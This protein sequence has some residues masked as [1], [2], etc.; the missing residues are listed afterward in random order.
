MMKTECQDTNTGYPTLREAINLPNPSLIIAANRAQPHIWN[1]GK[2]TGQEKDR[3]GPSDIPPPSSTTG[4][5][6]D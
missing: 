3:M 1:R 5:K 6:S 4:V 2:D